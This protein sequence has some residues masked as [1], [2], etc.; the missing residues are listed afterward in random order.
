M[1]CK[2]DDCHTKRGK[3]MDI[4]KDMS[5]GYGVKRAKIDRHL[6]NL[7]EGFINDLRKVMARM[8]HVGNNKQISPK[9]SE[10]T[11][12]FGVHLLDFVL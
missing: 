1:A 2:C 10:K 6:K 12:T 11:R 4:L 3:F 7:P 9:Q 5:E 8:R